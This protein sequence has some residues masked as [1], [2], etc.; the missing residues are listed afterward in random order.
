MQA[1]P[2]SSDT[3]PLPRLVVLALQ[4]VLVMY[5]GAMAVPLILGSA[6][7]LPKDQIA[8]LINTDLF[9]CGVATIIQSHGFGP[10]GIRLPV[11]MGVTFASVSPMLAMAGNPALGLTAI[12]GS[13]IAAGAFGLAI[14]PFIGKL[15]RF[16]PWS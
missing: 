8:L 11:M 3:P 1:G 14:A 6:L 4:H 2:A 15:L 16:F 9:A 12:F 13:V 10:V 7:K 5:A